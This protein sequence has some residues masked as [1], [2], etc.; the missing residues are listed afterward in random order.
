MAEITD[1]ERL[2]VEQ[3]VNDL[4]ERAK[5]LLRSINF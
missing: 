5:K 2:A 3:M 4:I 1:E